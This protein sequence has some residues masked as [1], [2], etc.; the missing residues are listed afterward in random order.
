M[1]SYFLASEAYQGKLD[2]IEKLKIQAG[3]YRK[4]KAVLTRLRTLV[5]QQVLPS[6]NKVASHLLR[7]MTGGQR[8]LIVVDD[9][10]DVMVDNQHLD[11]LSGSGKAC[12]NLAL[13]IGLAQVLTNRIFSTLLADEI[14][15]SMDA[16]RAEK[17]ADV[18]QTLVNSISQVIL[19]SH[20]DVEAE[21]RIDLGDQYVRNE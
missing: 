20:K 17:T 12:V 11:T 16:F 2:E 7:Q 10:F 21:H 19:V 9:E 18:L 8:Q 6:L 15:A 14:D 1:E 5:K 4:M 13:R 3:E